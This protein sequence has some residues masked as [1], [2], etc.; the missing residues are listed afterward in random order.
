LTKELKES[1]PTV[2]EIEAEFANES[3]KIEEEASIS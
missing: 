2:E 3:V 1:L